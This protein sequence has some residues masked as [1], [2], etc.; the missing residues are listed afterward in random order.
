MKRVLITRRLPEPVLA[1]AGTLFDT[2]LWPD[3]EPIGAQ[4]PAWARGCDGLLVM[5]TDRLDAATL[6][7]LPPTVR[8][9]ATYS[10]GHDHID[11]NAA[12]QRGIPVC[13]T[14]DVL[15]DAVAEVALLLILAAARDAATAE[16]QLRNGEWG[17]WSPTR[18]LGRQLTSQRLG[19]Y[20][21]GRIGLGIAHR[22]QAFGMKVHYHNRTEHPS[23][24]GMQHHAS[25]ESLMAHSDVF[26]V[27]APSTPQTRGVINRDRLAL[28]PPGAV[29][30]NIARGDLVDEDALIQAIT[31]G[32]VGGAGLDVY[33][34]EPNIDPRFIRLPRTTLLPHIGSATHEARI[35]MGRLALDALRAVL[36]DAQPPAHCLNPEAM[37]LSA[38]EGTA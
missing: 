13:N 27:C 9:I 37:A 14:P 6:R 22:A 5:A 29:F 28:L 34:N 18:F 12:S 36:L 3:D 33:R 32:Q 1:Q 17:P 23:A 30:V 21:M 4:L 11:L 7:S 10:V 20:G 15:S 19:I 16:T 31:T 26:C 25:L 35:G 38:R 8:A 2:V 24:R